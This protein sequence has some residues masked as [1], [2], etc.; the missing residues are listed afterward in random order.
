MKIKVLLVDDHALFRDGM[1]YVLQQLADEVEI[2][3]TGSFSEGLQRVLAN[4][5]LDL[6][7]LDLNMPD[8]EG[9][10]SLQFF[11]QRFPDIPLVVVSGS[12]QRDDI[13]HVMNLG[14][15]G[16]ISK[17]SPSRTMLSALRMVLEGG[18]YVPPQLLQQAVAKLETG[19]ALNDKR[20]QRASKYGLTPRQLQVLQLLGAGK[21]NKEIS[22]LLN[23]AEGT[24]KIHVAAIYQTL[25]VN[26]R[27][28]AVATAHRF[29]FIADENGRAP[30]GES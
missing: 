9:V 10:S 6:A 1:R 5:D 8:S 4:P 21:S 18:V 20:S 26:S 19:Q 14:A 2:L 17:M 28:E 16:F 24:V 27:I 25:H 29:G 11:H 22:R 7:L 13:E 15:M 3:D 23:L 30:G 12:D